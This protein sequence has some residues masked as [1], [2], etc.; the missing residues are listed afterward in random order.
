VEVRI[1]KGLRA[2]EFG[3]NTVKRGVGL[4]VLILMEIE[5]ME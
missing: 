5:V 3:Q 4:D 1:P 2:D